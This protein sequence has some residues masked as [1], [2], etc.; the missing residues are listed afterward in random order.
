[1]VKNDNIITFIDEI[2]SKTP[3]RKYPTNKLVCNH[4]DEIWSTDLADFLDYKTSNNEGIRYI[5][6]INDKFS[7]FVW[8]ISLK[9]K[10][11]KTITDEFSNVLTKSKRKPI[12]VESD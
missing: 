3:M 11:S 10:F 1:M 8:A 2:C 6:I 5:F 4:I 12:K 7:E 9:N